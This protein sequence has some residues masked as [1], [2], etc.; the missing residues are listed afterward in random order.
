MPGLEAMRP[1]RPAP[2]VR[3]R[4]WSSGGSSKSPAAAL[5]ASWGVP[6]E[7]HHQ[8]DR[9]ETPPETLAA[10]AS[11]QVSSRIAVAGGVAA[12]KGMLRAAEIE[13][14]NPLV[15]GKRG[16]TMIGVIVCRQEQGLWRPRCAKEAASSTAEARLGSARRSPGESLAA[17]PG[18]HRQEAAAAAPVVLLGQ[19]YPAQGPDPELPGLPGMTPWVT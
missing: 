9:A 8:D 2:E 4:V 18:E 13:V 16:A 17:S 14:Q 7:R 11:A 5:V 6:H 19:S 10:P 12:A 1:Y 15:L 3:P